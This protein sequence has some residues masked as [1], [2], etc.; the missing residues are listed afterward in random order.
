MGSPERP[1][2]QPLAVP[3]H[4][5]DNSD[6]THKKRKLSPELSETSRS[7]QSPKRARTDHDSRASPPRRPPPAKGGPRSPPPSSRG[8]SDR[9]RPAPAASRADTLQEE[10]KRGKRLFGGLLSTLGGRAAAAPSTHQKR[11][12]DIERRQLE[13]AHKQ[14]A[15]DDRV[16]KERLA[17][18]EQIRKIEQISFDEQVVGNHSL[19]NYTDMRTRHADLLAKTR[20]LGTRSEPSIYYLPWRITEAQQEVIEKQKR[21]TEELIRQEQ[22]DF[23]RRKEQ[24]MRHLGVWRASDPSDVDAGGTENAKEKQ[25]EYMKDGICEDKKGTLSSTTESVAKESTEP[26]VTAAAPRATESSVEGEADD[27]EAG[28]DML[29]EAEDTVIY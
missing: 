5:D 11:R 18:L 16:R 26:R 12:Q 22:N 3:Q 19:Q 1:P 6:D 13:Q 14:K 10:K 17:K 4:V 2:S 28:D 8:A 7:R 23:A 20:F 24:R 15:V 25:D 27:A 29:E 9:G 21:E